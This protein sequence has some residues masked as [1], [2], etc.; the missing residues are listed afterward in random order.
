MNDSPCYIEEEHV[1]RNI[2]GDLVVC[3]HKLHFLC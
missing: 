2:E 1:E 3:E